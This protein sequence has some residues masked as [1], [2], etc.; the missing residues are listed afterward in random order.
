MDSAHVPPITIL[1][2]GQ[3]VIP[4]EFRLA[5]GFE[6]GTRVSEEMILHQI[7][8]EDTKTKSKMSSSQL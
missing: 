4:K 5:T 1:T 8:Q 2:K 3:V 7:E 6:A